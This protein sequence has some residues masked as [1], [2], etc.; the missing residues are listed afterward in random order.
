MMRLQLIIL[1][2]CLVAACSGTR[3]NPSVLAS[4]PKAADSQT[5]K[6]EEPG[7]DLNFSMKQTDWSPAVIGGDGAAML[8]E[9]LQK[10]TSLMIL[11]GPRLQDEILEDSIFQMVK[12]ASPETQIVA[13]NRGVLD[14]LLLE[15]GEIPYRETWEVGGQD[16]LG[17]PYLIPQKHPLK[18][19]WLSKKKALKGAEAILVMDFVT[20]DERKLREMRNQVRGGCS[21]LLLELERGKGQAATYFDA[22]VQQVNEALAA[23]F[24]RQMEAALPF[25][26]K[27]LADGLAMVEPSSQ[28]ARCYKA[29]QKFLSNYDD[30][31]GDSCA[32]APALY[33]EGGGV[34]GMEMSDA[35]IVPNNCPEGMGRNYVDELTA[36]GERVT[37]NIMAEIPSSWAG[38]FSK[39]KMLSSLG[40]SLEELCAPAHRRYSADDL[41]LAKQAVNAFIEQAV[42]QKQDGEF[43]AADG[44]ERIAGVGGVAVFG[45]AKPKGEQMNLMI[46]QLQGIFAP[47][48]KCRDSKRRPVQVVL[49]DVGTSEVYFSAIVFEEQL[50]CE[51][52]PPQ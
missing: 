19:D 18:T 27:E 49:V 34:L 20:P 36:I 43:S 29:Y 17:R 35:V 2:G 37:K 25:W 51:N 45:R 6:F 24:S 33:V 11:T 44:M 32:R 5:Q 10:K 3:P 46:K 7:E 1:T 22:I 42:S 40:E 16:V 4:T 38:E 30:C 15:R 31:L 9:A 47:L 8:T 13:R 50:F 26:K 41:E 48:N 28:D 52:L 39:V 12:A 23:E 14:E 21:D